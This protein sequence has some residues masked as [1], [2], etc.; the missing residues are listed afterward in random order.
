VQK[1]TDGSL[2]PSVLKN[3][4][5][6]TQQRINMVLTQNCLVVST[7]E[8]DALETDT[9]NN[10]TE[11]VLCGSSMC[12]PKTSISKILENTQFQS[13]KCNFL[14][15]MS[16]KSDP[17]SEADMPQFNNFKRETSLINLGAKKHTLSARSK[18]KIRQKITAWSR[19]DQ[20]RSGLR[21]TFI[22]LTLTSQ[23]IGTHKD[24][25]K[26]VNTFFTYLRKYYG[27]TNYL[28][29][30]EIQTLTTNNIHTHVLHDRWLPVQTVNRIWCKILAENGYTFKGGAIFQQVDG[31]TQCMAIKY[32]YDLKRVSTYVT[33]YVTKNDSSLDCS[34]WNCS[35]SISR[36]F[37][38]VKT[39]DKNTFSVLFEHVRHTIQAKLTN[40]EVLHIHLLSL[41]HGIQKKHFKINER[42]LAGK[43][44][45]EQ[46]IEQI[47]QAQCRS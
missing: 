5:T 1:K 26:M 11:T 6:L 20:K 32:V 47:K 22:T 4:T 42:V 16:V 46:F 21:F 24:Y 25:I 29:V 28:Y 27:F 33:K 12:R 43:L 37:T 35:N 23:Q 13:E 41:Y 44:D 18:T 14:H 19:V 45:R 15:E 17:L 9:Y 40:G 30:N 36:L 7:K 38:S 8:L 31:K 3:F 2:L 39:W 10:R 34:I